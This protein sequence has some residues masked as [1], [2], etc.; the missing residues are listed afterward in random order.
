[1]ENNPSYSE[2]R[3][4]TN[5]SKEPS[6]LDSS[7]IQ[8]GAVHYSSRWWACDLHTKFDVQFHYCLFVF[9]TA[10]YFLHKSINDLYV[11]I[12]VQRSTLVYILFY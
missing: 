3:K 5:L 7:N 4:D 9:L 12:L 10:H 8:T 1:M 6:L 2:L 11:Y